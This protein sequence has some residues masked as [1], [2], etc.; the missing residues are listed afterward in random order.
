MTENSE[1]D[2]ECDMASLLDM[3]AS[4]LGGHDPRDP[5]ASPVFGH[6]EGLRAL[7]RV[8][9][10]DEVLLD[11]S[12]RRVRAAAL[13]GVDAHVHIRPGMRHVFPIRRGAF[14]EADAEIGRAAAWIRKRT[15]AWSQG[16][17]GKVDQGRLRG[18]SDFAFR[19]AASLAEA[20]PLPPFGSGDGPSLRSGNQ[21]AGRS[22]SKSNFLL[23][24]AVE[25]DV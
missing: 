3:A 8:V 20:K 24:A 7:L 17:S 9:G 21:K 25:C 19:T 12:L 13:G 10:G 23:T 14:P 11:D 2:L 15:G 18:R 22:L 5:L 16:R 4:Y 6:F 1:R